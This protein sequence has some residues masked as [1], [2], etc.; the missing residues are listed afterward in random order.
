MQKEDQRPARVDRRDFIRAA[1]LAGIAGTYPG[2]SLVVQDNSMP[3]KTV[4]FKDIDRLHQSL[5]G[6]HHVMI[7]GIYEK[8]LREEMIRMGVGI[9]G[10][11]DMS[12]PV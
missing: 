2:T 10:P 11:S 7:A 9:I 6:C 4:E 3:L 8:T 1:A 5:E 12:S